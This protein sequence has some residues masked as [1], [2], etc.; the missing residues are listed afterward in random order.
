[1]EAH[2][3]PPL[4][5]SDLSASQLSENR[6]GHWPIMPL[7]ILCD[8]VGVCVCLSVI[9]WQMWCLNSAASTH[10]DLKNISLTLSQIIFPYF[11][12]LLS[13]PQFVVGCFS[14]CA[15][16]LSPLVSCPSYP[17]AQAW[18]DLL[19]TL[20]EPK[21]INTQI[22]TFFVAPSLPVSFFSIPVHL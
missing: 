2:L 22:T 19:H 16:V 3:L 20:R 18:C 15:N 8:S 21:R 13:L 5:N 7:K 9:P 14:R 1:M 17:R 11:P 4:L 6:N 10:T 12:M